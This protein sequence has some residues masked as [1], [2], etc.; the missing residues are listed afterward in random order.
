MGD[1]PEAVGDLALLLHRLGLVVGRV[2][3]VV[4]DQHVDV[5]VERGGEEHRLALLV[6][7]VEEAADLGQEPHVGHAVGLVDHD[8]VD[9][10]EAQRAAVEQVL[11][12][13]GGGHHD[14]DA[15]AE[16]LASACSMP[17]PP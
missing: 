16:R 6:G 5:A 14:L 11:E 1:G 12:A 8:E 2:R 3:L 13:A 17:A 15:L 9:V 4:P 7:H 10:V